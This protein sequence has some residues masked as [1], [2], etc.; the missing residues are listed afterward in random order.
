MFKRKIEKCKN[1]TGK[2]SVL[3]LP[4]R[5]NIFFC[6]K[7]NRSCPVY[8][9]GGVKI[10]Q[11]NITTDYAIR[12]L[13]FLAINNKT[14]SSQEIS[15]N[16]GIPKSYVL[17]VI[18]QL[19]KAGMTESYSGKNGGVSLL[20]SPENITLL[21]ILQVMES[22]TKINRCLEEDRYCSRFATDN[23][24][25]RKFY[26]VLQ[27]ELENKLKEITISSLIKT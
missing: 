11:L 20:K 6:L 7:Q 27:E 14:T 25:V 18:Q 15:E 10:T 23:C 16:M 17:K 22:T 21:D 9:L 5:L 13:I 1:P 24:P 2:N 26:C 12:I 8:I 19:S 4:V 3:F